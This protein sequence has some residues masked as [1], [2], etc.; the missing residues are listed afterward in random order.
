VC[1]YYLDGELLRAL[2]AHELY[3]LTFCASPDVSGETQ[4]RPKHATGCARIK[5]VAPDG[6]PLHDTPRL[7]RSA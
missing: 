3:F 5:R 4:E 1:P 7:K 6:E 2:S